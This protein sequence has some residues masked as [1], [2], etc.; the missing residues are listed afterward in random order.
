VIRHTIIFAKKSL[1]L[2][3]YFSCRV[4]TKRALS[5][6]EESLPELEPI[7]RPTDLDGSRVR[8]QS[9]PLESAAF[10]SD[11]EVDIEFERSSSLQNEGNFPVE[12][13]NLKEEAASGSIDADGNFVQTKEQQLDERDAWLD[14]IDETPAC[15][16]ANAMDK[17]RKNAEMTSNFW[18]SI[19]ERAPGPDQPL[20]VY[21]WRVCS[22]LL[23][24]E[25]PRVAIARCLGVT[26]SSTGV[27]KKSTIRA[28]RKQGKESVSDPS[29][30][31]K[32]VSKFESITEATDALIALG[33]HDVLQLTREYLSTRLEKFKF[34]YIWKEKN[35]GEIHGPFSFNVLMEWAKQGCFQAHPIQVRYAGTNL[36]WRD[37]SPFA[38]VYKPYSVFTV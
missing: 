32:D 30:S 4:M 27:P 26:S 23:D 25:T 1:R 36:P 7:R 15:V 9:S 11:N 3:I 8:N 33:I 12:P 34:E 29:V 35:D 19:E 24:G 16:D 20:E 14:S 10:S 2:E 17:S 6:G 38:L 37:F 31:C 13:F 22:L 21:I 18:G 28:K 5:D